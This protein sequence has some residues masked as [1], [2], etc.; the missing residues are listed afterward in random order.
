MKPRL[1]ASGT[2]ASPS[3][4]KLAFN[5]D[6]AAIALALVLAGLVRFGVLPHVGW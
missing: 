6:A 3:H 1:Q 2:A 5:A 4:G